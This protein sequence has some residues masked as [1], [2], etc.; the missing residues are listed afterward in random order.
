MEETVN[1]TARFLRCRLIVFVLVLL[2]IG[3][4]R[5]PYAEAQ[6]IPGEAIKTDD[7]ALIQKIKEEIMKE[8]RE[9]EFLRQQIEIGIQD[10]IKKQQQAQ[11]A[12][13]VATERLAN[14]KARTYAASLA[15]GTTSTAIPTHRYP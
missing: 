1:V 14:E 12:T 15:V 5:F 7:R 8:L 11:V 10:H 9:G 2:I 4:P 3:L 13:R 6:Q